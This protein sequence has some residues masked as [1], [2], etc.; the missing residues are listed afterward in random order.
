V[1]GEFSQLLCLE[2]DHDKILETLDA[3]TIQVKN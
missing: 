2:P 3:P 1:R